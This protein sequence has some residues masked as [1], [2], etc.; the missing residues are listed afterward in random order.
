LAFDPDGR[1]YVTISE[2]ANPAI[3]HFRLP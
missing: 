3:N 1:G 2:G